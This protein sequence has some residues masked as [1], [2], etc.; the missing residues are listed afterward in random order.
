ML[1]ADAA[2][3]MQ[4]IG[5]L[6]LLQLRKRPHSTLST[7]LCTDVVITNLL[8]LRRSAIVRRYWQSRFSCFATA[9]ACAETESL[10]LQLKSAG[11]SE[12]LAKLN[13]L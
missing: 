7:D 2:A 10:S 13:Y 3:R 1:A 6:Q 8:R 4:L 11:S 12:Q 5:F 9:S